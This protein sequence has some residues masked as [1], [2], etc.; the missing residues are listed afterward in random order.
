MTAEDTRNGLNQHERD[1]DA[2][3]RFDFDQR[4]A[5]KIRAGM[6]EA[7][8]RRW[9]RGSSS[10][11]SSGLKKNR[12]DARGARLFE[13]LRRDVSYTPCGCSHERRVSPRLLSRYWRWESGSTPR[14]FTLTNTVLFRRVSFGQRQ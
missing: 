6:N 9:Q 8:A 3:L 5:E 2:E 4:V 10:V 13:S 1:L 7:Q 12:R 11:E 14:S